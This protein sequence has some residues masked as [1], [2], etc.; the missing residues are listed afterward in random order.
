MARL[1]DI[2]SIGNAYSQKLKTAGISSL[3]KLLEN[4]SNR[5]GRTEIAKKSGISE[6]KILEWVNRADLTRIKGVST[7]YADL[8]EHT[9]VDSIPELAQRNPDKLYLMMTKVN[10]KKQI[11]RKLPSVSQIKKWIKQADKLPRVITH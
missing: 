8:L 10:N 1:K 5:K 3:N 6:N 11:V 2:E 7:Q 9:G 4:G